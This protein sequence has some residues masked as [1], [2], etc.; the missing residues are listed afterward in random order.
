MTLS[1]A[2]LESDLSYM[3][4]DLPCVVV[5]GST[6]LSGTRSEINQENNNEGMYEGQVKAFD[7]I[8]V[9]QVSQFTDES[10]DLPNV[11]D[12][13]TVSG[14]KYLIETK[15]PD[16]AGIGVTFGLRRQESA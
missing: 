12:V 4:T 6:T 8:L 3:V 2:M 14:V 10:I 5:V 7:F 15:E 9:M 13:I 11:R 1:T 16:Q